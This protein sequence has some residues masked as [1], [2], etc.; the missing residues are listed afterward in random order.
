MISGIIALTLLAFGALLSALHASLSDLVRTTLEE[1][2]EASPSRTRKAA[3]AA[4]LDD[5]PGH[6]RAVAFL[7]TPCSLGA[8]I[9]L[10][11]LS[12]A[13]RGTPSPTWL[14]GLIGGAIAAALLWVFSVLI[15]EAVSRHAGER[16]VFALSRLVRAIHILAAPLRPLAM[17]F[18]SLFRMLTGTRPE[19][20]ADQVEAEVLSALDEAE[21]EGGVDE[22]ERDMIESVMEIKDLTVEQIM[23]PRNEIEALELTSNLGQVAAFVRKARHSRIPVYRSGAGL[24]EI[25]GIFYVKDLLRWLAGEG[26]HSGKGFDLRTILRPAMVVP[27]SKTIRELLD[28]FVAKRV[29]VAIVADEYGGTAGIVSLEDII[30]EVFGEI[31]DEYEK[32]EDDPPRIDIRAEE[33]IVECD[34]R[35]AIHDLN[36]ALEPF[37]VSIPEGEDYDTIAGYALAAFGRIPETNESILMGRT[38]ITVLEATPTRI[39]KVR[40]QVKPEEGAE[41]EPAPAA[42]AS[43]EGEKGK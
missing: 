30:E 32:A 41:A 19:D 42:A 1:M 43:R 4:I 14:D 9:A 5:V 10:V 7:R 15:P 40:I 37:G 3:I 31:Q 33:S 2:A 13:I 38:A 17:F 25:V 8:A 11:F 28:E 6:A 18:D 24:D 12:A 22:R 27:E 21:R 39:V 34:A 16:L 20:E 23:T 35:T 36:D 29:H 26:A